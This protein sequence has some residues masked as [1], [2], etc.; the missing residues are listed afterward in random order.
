MQSRRRADQGGMLRTNKA[1][2]LNVHP[3]TL[4]ALRDA[5]EIEQVGRGIA[6]PSH[7]QAPK[8]DS[9]PIR[10]YWYPD[11]SFRAGVEVITID[12]V[13]VRIYSPEKAIADGF[14]YRNKIGLDVALEALRSYRERTRKPNRP[15]LVKFARISPA[16]LSNGAHSC[17]EADLTANPFKALWPPGGPW[18]SESP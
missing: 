2:R 16:E 9:V 17:A 14:K 15:A 5:G 8:F 1:I 18:K 6:L 12:D 10:V 13:P 4:Y 7:A 11:A 3:R